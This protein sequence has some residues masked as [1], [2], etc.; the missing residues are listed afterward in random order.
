MDN[1]VTLEDVNRIVAR[2]SPVAIK[3][4]NGFLH[5][6]HRLLY[7]PPIGVGFNPQSC[8]PLR[9]VHGVTPAALHHSTS[10]PYSVE[11]FGLTHSRVPEDEYMVLLSFP[12]MSVR[13]LV[14]L[15]LVVVSVQIH[16]PAAL[17]SK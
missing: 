6:A 14:V 2:C 8:V 15:V 3:Q 4:L 11:S 9:R 10:L 13:V 7:N 16:E 17:Q 12:L 1:P 5:A